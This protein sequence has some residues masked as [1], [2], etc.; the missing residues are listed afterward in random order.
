[1]EKRLEKDQTSLHT[2][3]MKG[4]ACEEDARL[5]IERW[6]GK[7]P[8]Y[9]TSQVG[10][11]VV[12]QRKNGT[13]GR[14][15]KGEEL[16]MR[17]YPTCTLSY[18]MEI[19]EQERSRMGRFILASN[20]PSLSPDE[21]LQYYKEQSKVEKGFRFLKD[22]SFHVAD[23]FLE[24]ENRIAAL[25]M[26]MVLCLLIYTFAEWMIRK[27]LE[28]QDKTV[29]G[30]TGKST[31]KPSAK[32]MFQLYRRVRELKEQCGEYVVCRIVNYTEE[33]REISRLLGPNIEKYY[34]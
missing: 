34:L 27:A 30:Q 15:K 5:A 3:L 9:D 14:P 24:N 20:D 12:N 4:F 17:V 8:R 7:H 6:I 18:N 28:E 2:L 31:K 32:W 23:V 25:S 21:C 29:R 26:I 1:M 16:V 33:L 22:D 10:Y 13:R 19:V 11:K